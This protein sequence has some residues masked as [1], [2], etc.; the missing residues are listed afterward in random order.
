MRSQR[1]ELPID[2][3]VSNYAREYAGKRS[4]IE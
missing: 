4:T 3:I 2:P 1:I